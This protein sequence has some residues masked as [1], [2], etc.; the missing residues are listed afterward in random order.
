MQPS[1]LQRHAARCELFQP[2]TGLSML[3]LERSGWH[4]QRCS[5][6]S[7]ECSCPCTPSPRQSTLL[8]CRVTCD[9]MGLLCD[10][11]TLI[12]HSSKFT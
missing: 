9:H 2:K 11:S 3:V 4:R 5:A 7:A 6:M 10:M 12:T 8:E 1:V